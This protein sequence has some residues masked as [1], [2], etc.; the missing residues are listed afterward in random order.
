MSLFEADED[1]YFIIGGDLNARIGEWFFMDDNLD[2][3]F[4]QQKEGGTFERQSQD[5]VTNVFGKTLIS[6]CTTFQFT[7]LNGLI[8]GDRYG[9]FTFFSERGQSTIDYFLCSVDLIAYMKSLS[10]SGKPSRVSL[11]IINVCL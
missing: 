7:P 8:D 11:N 6:L 1:V 9:Q 3:D 5:Q 2:E 4:R 10:L